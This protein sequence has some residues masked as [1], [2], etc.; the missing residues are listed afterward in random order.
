MI[1]EVETV[2][3]QVVPAIGAAIG[4]YGTAVLTQAEDGAASLTVRSG[5]RFL[6]RVLRRTKN[7]A[8][9]ESAVRSAAE[10][11]PDA[12][13]ALR[14]Q[15]RTDLKAD[16]ELLKELAALLPAQP[17]ASATGERAAVV[18]GGSVGIVSLGDDAVNI[19]RG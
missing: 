19:A 17:A 6:N 9:I 3:G 15:I 5:Q 11:N 14:Y 1:P 2:L 18:S 4:A 13:V 16:A 10:G 8:L 12:L 7:P